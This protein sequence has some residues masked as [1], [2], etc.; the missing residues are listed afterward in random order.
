[1]HPAVAIKTEY[2]AG[3]IGS[4]DFGSSVRIV[5]R[6]PR[7]VMFIGYGANI[8]LRHSRGVRAVKIGKRFSQEL[9]QNENARAEITKHFGDGGVEAAGLALD[10]KGYGTVLFD[11][12]GEALRI[13]AHEARLIIQAEYNSITPT[14]RIELANILTC[15]QCGQPLKPSTDYHNMSGKIE[16]N[17]PKTFEDAQRMTNLSVIAIHG[18]EQVQDREFWP[19]I[20]W[21]ETWD[22]M[23][24]HDSVFC[25]DFCAATYGRRAVLESPLLPIGGERPQNVFRMPE[26]HYHYDQEKEEERKRASIEKFFSKRKT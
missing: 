22:G 14:M 26:T 9:L 23:S 20:S 3:Q 17:H 25:N 10:R 7:A 8:M 16:V 24:Y 11:G 19:Y 5:M 6:S 13:P 1:M 4:A 18:Y 15:A 2:A 21:F 12:G